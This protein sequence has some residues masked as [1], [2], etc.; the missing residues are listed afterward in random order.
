M[1]LPPPYDAYLAAWSALR[2]GDPDASLAVLEALAASPRY[3]LW[4]QLAL[5]HFLEAEGRSERAAQARGA[6]AR[7][8]PLFDSQA[9]A[10]KRVFWNPLLADGHRLVAP[11][12]G[13]LLSRAGVQIEAAFQI[14]PRPT[15]KLAL[16]VS[17]ARTREEESPPPGQALQERPRSAACGS[18]GRVLGHLVEASGA[19]GGLASA[20]LAGPGRSPA[21]RRSAAVAGAQAR[22]LPPGPATGRRSSGE[23]PKYLPLLGLGRFREALRQSQILDKEVGSADLLPVRGSAR[24]PDSGE[25]RTA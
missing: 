7:Q 12:A 25:R 20:G 1:W 23:V 19:R 3:R 9:Q 11:C 10:P 15:S 17:R 16:I 13:R 2:G 8:H 14:D 4:G 5:A 21:G 22:E 18:L 24:R 6:L